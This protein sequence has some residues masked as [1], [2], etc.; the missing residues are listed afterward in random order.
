MGIIKYGR[1][2]PT[3]N[4]LNEGLYCVYGSNGVIG[5][6]NDYQ[7]SQRMVAISCRGNSSGTIHLT[8]EKS[9]ITSNS[10]YIEFNNSEYTNYFYIEFLKN[11]LYEY[12]TGSAQPQITIENLSKLKIFIPKD[13]SLYNSNVNIIVEFIYLLKKE[14]IKLQKL[15]QNYLLKFFQ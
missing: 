11:G 2:I 15:K 9:T 12:K 7:F 8:E 4:I 14:N 5:Y 3:K 10:L 1:G 13:I 6:L